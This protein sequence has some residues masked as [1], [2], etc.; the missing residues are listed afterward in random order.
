MQLM[1]KI[2]HLIAVVRY[3]LRNHYVEQLIISVL[4]TE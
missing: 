3:V 2:R 4:Q 1:P